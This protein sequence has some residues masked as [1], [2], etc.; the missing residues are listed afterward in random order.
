[1]ARSSALSLA[2]ASRLTL[3]HLLIYSI[4]CSCLPCDTQE[5]DPTKSPFEKPVF[6]DDSPRTALSILWSSLATIFACIWVSVHPNVP[7]PKMERKGWL[8]LNVLRRAELMI[9]SVIAPEFVTIWAL[10]QHSVARLIRAR[11]PE[12]LTMSHGFLVSMGGF[13]YSDGR[14]ITLDN[15]QHDTRLV[16]WL[17]QIKKKEIGDRSKGDGLSK[18]VA[19]G[20]SAWFLLQ[21]AARLTQHLPLTMLEI[22]AIGYAFFTIVNYAVWWHKPLEISVPFQVPIPSEPM[23]TTP[24]PYISRSPPLNATALDTF[25]AA[26]RPLPGLFPRSLD[27]EHLKDWASFRLLSLFLGGDTIPD[28][29]GPSSEEGVPRMWSGHPNNTRLFLLVALGNCMGIFFGVIYCAAWN[30][31]FI[32]SME[33]IL[34]RA[35]SI[36]FALAPPSAIVVTFVTEKTAAKLGF[37]QPGR[38]NRLF[39]FIYGSIYI[40]L[41]VIYDM[42]RVFSLT[43]PYLALRDLPDGA[44]QSVEW[45]K[46]LPH[47]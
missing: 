24:F 5:I 21:C 10:R 3:L 35:C 7:G 33:R 36:I 30:Y 26:L 47:I 2:S 20:Q 15:L 39:S 22:V 44:S 16:A 41:W 34:W 32:T 45:T 14:P 28:V 12:T 38:D 6:N 42:A 11:C 9:L 13:V 17:G 4:T 25:E 8:Y 27:I 43:E 18:A 40:F 19:I 1:M 37:D 29:D 23:Q 46:F 31:E